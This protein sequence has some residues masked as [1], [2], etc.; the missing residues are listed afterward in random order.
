MHYEY[1]C[2][3]QR[4]P[5]VSA[6]LPITVDRAS[7]DE[8]AVD[9]LGDAVLA[10]LRAYRCLTRH[11]SE[12]TRAGW[13]ALQV[14][15]VIG[16]DEHRLSELAELRGVDQSVISRQIG[17][18]QN[19]GLVCRR[20]DPS[21]RRAGLV[22]LTATGLLLHE[23]AHSLRRRWLRGSLARTPSVDVR[24]AAALISALAAELDAHAAELGPSAPGLDPDSPTPRPRTREAKGT[25][26]G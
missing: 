14:A 10:L 13:A 2:V 7:A 15:G 20:P 1:G 8:Q 12:S 18:L 21:D 16:T 6:P 3:M 11:G 17:D 4:S 22:R 24:T 5:V 25:T 9:D 26:A 19:R 23:H